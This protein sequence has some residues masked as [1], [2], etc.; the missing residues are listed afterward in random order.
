MGILDG[1]RIVDLSVGMAGSIATM[2]LAEVGADVVLVEGPVSGSERDQPGFRTWNRSKRSVVLDLESAA[3]RAD[4]ET[5]LA[6][7]DV[8]VHELGPSTASALGLDDAALAER[9]PHLIASSVLAWPT[10]HPNADM[11]V[12]E[13]LAMAS[14]GV[15]DEQLA[16]RRQ[17]PVFLRAPLGSV[18]AVYSASVGILARL[19]ARGRTGQIGPA[20]TSLV[21]GAL[22][23]MGMHWHPAEKPSPMLTMGMPKEGRGSQNTIYEC[24][25]GQW[26]HLMGDPMRV[27]RVATYVADHENESPAT[28]DIS[29]WT[30]EPS[31]IRDVFFTAPRDEWL[32]EMWANDV[33]AQ[34]C[35]EFGDVFSDEQARL[36]GYVIDFDDPETGPITVAGHPLTVSP[37]Q[38]VQSPAPS[39]GQHTAEVLGS[40]AQA[41]PELGD[42]PLQ[43]HPLQGVKVIDFGNYLAGP[44]AAQMFAD[45]GADVVKIEAATGD[46]M[47]FADW[48]FAGCQRGKRSVALDLKSADARSALEAALK[49]ADVV[50]HNL[51]M[52]AA[53]RLGL[54]YESVKAVNPDVVFCHTSSY[55][56]TGPR[57][58]W[59][60]YDQLF[61]AQCGWEVLGAG[62]D[63]PP[64][65]HRFGFMDHQCAMSSALATLLALYHRDRT[66]EGQATA[67]SL[68]GAGV[69][70]S[71]ETYLRPDGTLAPFD[72]LDPDQTG[73]SESRR[74]L[75][76]G[77]GWV[78]VASD[79]PGQ[80]AAIAAIESETATVDEAL[81]ALGAA[82]VPA[83]RVELDQ[84]Q[85]FFDDT[86]NQAAGLVADYRHAEWGRL[87]QPGAL[88][89][90]GEDMSVQLHLAPPE[91]GE[92]TSECLV[93]FGVN[94]ETVEALLND[95]VAVQYQR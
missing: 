53:R 69:M 33:P 7:A 19:I 68:L 79:D 12:D 5:L 32:D 80:V 23:P 29:G 25:D 21:Q 28:H 43:V 34:I 77:D 50:H 55:G 94:K 3:G 27:P 71:S 65:W 6:G 20:H 36:N 26:M 48:P 13:L 49:W 95:G 35:A 83:V 66:G 30:P 85:A 45:L 9:H 38:A 62:E 18:G 4:L 14:L 42:G 60:G 15:C 67:G 74:F 92:H 39:H 81:A 40:W 82:G 54:D 10:N 46:P 86:A 89:Y 56:P 76:R 57:A 88:W 31:H 24:G 41:S 84:G 47:R 51:R 93:E 64:M 11:P 63:N 59:P 17:G 1:V 78:A 16:W 75:E 70:A 22:V 91:L 87:Q 44:Y 58:D 61:Q 72:L 52:P 73:V 2:L 90:F 8:V 37:P